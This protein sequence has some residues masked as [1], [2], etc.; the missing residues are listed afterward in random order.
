MSHYENGRLA[1]VGD[2]VVGT[3]YN[4]NGEIIAGTLVSITPGPDACS[5]MV[6]F[7]YVRM[8]DESGKFAP[9]HVPDTLV[10]LQGTANH[11]SAGEM[12]AVYYKQDYTE[13]KNLLHAE[14]AL[15]AFEETWEGIL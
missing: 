10:K 2:K 5:A 13:C 3:T 1:K 11:G 9:Y 14:D 12:S 15:H 4:T 7:S 8:A 6:G